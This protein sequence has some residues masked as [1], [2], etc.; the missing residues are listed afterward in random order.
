[1]SLS[2]TNAQTHHISDSRGTHNV[3]NGY[4][5]PLNIGRAYSTSNFPKRKQKRSMRRSTSTT[6]S[7]LAL[8]AF[9]FFLNILQRSLDESKQGPVLMTRITKQTKIR[10]RNDF[11]EDKQATIETTTLDNII[12]KKFENI[13]NK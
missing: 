12:V 2:A 7:A 10:P 5:L 13:Y 9:L 4:L 6:S 1:M 3:N 11:I 8:L